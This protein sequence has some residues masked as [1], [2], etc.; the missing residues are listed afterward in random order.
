MNFIDN[1][2][3]PPGWGGGEIYPLRQVPRGGASVSETG[4]AL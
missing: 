2:P 4:L 3:L 1:R